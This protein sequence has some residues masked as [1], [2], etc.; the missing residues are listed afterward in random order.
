MKR[1]IDIQFNV[2]IW[3]DKETNCYIVHVPQLDVF[4][5]GKTPE[6]ARKNIKDAVKG[7]LKTANEIGTLKQIL[8]EAGFSFDKEWKAPEFVAFEQARLAF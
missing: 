4:S 5:S 7:F 2:E 1:P 6:Q 3:K 8:E